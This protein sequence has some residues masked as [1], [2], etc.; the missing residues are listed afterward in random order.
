MR[1]KRSMIFLNQTCL[2]LLPSYLKIMSHLQWDWLRYICQITF[3][4]T[5]LNF[6]SVSNAKYIY[7]FVR[8]SMHL[9]WANSSYQFR[10]CR[11]TVR[12]GQQWMIWW[13]RTKGLWFLLRRRIKKLLKVLLTSGITWLKINV[14]F[15]ETWIKHDLAREQLNKMMFVLLCRW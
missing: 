7:G 9:D 10:E 4:T 13:S 14:S 8:C 1:S 3:D 6:D 5:V 2:R 15:Y 12:T 11:K